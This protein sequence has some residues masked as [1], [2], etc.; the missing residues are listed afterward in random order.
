MKTL[1]PC[2]AVILLASGL[3]QAAKACFCAGAIA[4]H[5]Q[6]TDRNRNS[7]T[8]RLNENRNGNTEMLIA[9]IR[10]STGQTT[11]YLDKAIA[12]GEKVQDS[13]DLNS[14]LRQREAFRATAEGGRYDPA[15]SSC[16]GLAAAVAI[17]APTPP[18]AVVSATGIDTQNRS[19]NYE[20][21]ADGDT[22]VCDG[23]GGVVA[24][25]I[26]DRDRSVGIG[27]VLDPTSDLRVLLTQPTAGAGT[28][29]DREKLDAAIWRLSQNIVNPFPER[30]VTEGESR[31][32]AGRVAIAERQSEAARRSAAAN[33]LGWIQTRSTANLPL[34]DWA[35][36]TAP[37]GYPY[38]I[39]DSIS[40]RQYYD[41]AVAA[42]WRNP[43]WH[44]RVAAMSPEAVTRE[45]L[46]QQALAN[47]LA[48]LQFELDVQRGAVDAV[49]A[50]RLLDKPL[51][52]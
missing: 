28:A 51:D 50:A 38:P 15:S 46:L 9:A 29:A 35:R 42:G 48:L 14:S 11:A 21:C 3:P 49:I 22:E 47:D 18:D 43:E 24:G 5:Q 16:G 6:A 12:A 36:R 17:S 32:A 25:I 7:N 33:L 39:D 8:E 45:L 4:A 52:G 40:V 41:V 23:L 44:Q 37:A 31:T 2:L 19:R 34:G 26:E 10:E 20:R 27:G 1:I 13:S 30:P